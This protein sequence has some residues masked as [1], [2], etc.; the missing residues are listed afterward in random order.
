MWITSSLA[1]SGRHIPSAE[2]YVTATGLK[3][4]KLHGR[5]SRPKTML[6]S[7]RI[8]ISKLIGEYVRIPSCSNFQ[9]IKSNRQITSFHNFGVP[10]LLQNCQTAISDKVSFLTFVNL[11]HNFN[12]PIKCLKFITYYQTIRI[13]K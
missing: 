10:V 6:L 1:I 8:D 2:R 5:K 11:F 9:E 4:L 12:P 7:C 3:E 13:D